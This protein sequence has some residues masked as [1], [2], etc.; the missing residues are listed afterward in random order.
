MTEKFQKLMKDSRPKV[1]E[2]LKNKKKG[3]FKKKNKKKNRLRDN[4]VNS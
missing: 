2:V 4:T 1:Q 3:K